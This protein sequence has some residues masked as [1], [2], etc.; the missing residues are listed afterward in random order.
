MLDTLDADFDIS[1]E[2]EQPNMII[3]NIEG[4]KVD[5]VKMNYPILF[6]TLLVEGVRMLDLRDIAPMKLKAI[7]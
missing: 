1:V 3:T 5:F 6:P 4:I 2:S 7:A